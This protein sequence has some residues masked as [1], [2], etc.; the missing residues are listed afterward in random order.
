MLQRLLVAIISLQ[1]SGLPLVSSV[2]TRG[3]IPAETWLPIHHTDQVAGS[4]ASEEYLR[5][6]TQLDSLISQTNTVGSRGAL[7]KEHAPIGREELPA[8]PQSANGLFN[9][10]AVHGHHSQFQAQEIASE[11]ENVASERRFYATIVERGSASPA[12]KFRLAQMMINGEGASR[13]LRA[14]VKILLENALAGDIRSQ[15]FLGD[16]FNSGIEN[17]I[18]N[19]ELGAQWY[20]RAAV[21]GSPEAQLKLADYYASTGGHDIRKLNLYRAA[22]EQSYPPAMLKWATIVF[23]GEFGLPRDTPLAMKLL[24]RSALWHGYN[25]S[26]LEMIKMYKRRIGTPEEMRV[27]ATLLPVLR[28]TADYGDVASMFELAEL[29]KSGSLGNAKNNVDA[30]YWYFKAAEAG[31]PESLKRL[32]KL[33]DNGL[34]LANVFLGSLKRN[35][36]GADALILANGRMAN[37]VSNMDRKTRPR[38]VQ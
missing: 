26:L 12:A 25:P 24:G 15:V 7:H 30:P 32:E 38:E 9:G 18:P 29:Y 28:K 16:Y 8:L 33:G 2:P 13:E 21:A 37:G 4:L 27:A 3:I 14:G 10:E 20:T 6:Q 35:G 23:N 1:V 19:P 11:S 22:M 31:H 5:L 36:H 34:V 17:T